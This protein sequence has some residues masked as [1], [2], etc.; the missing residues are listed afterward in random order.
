MTIGVLAVPSLA[1]KSRLALEFLALTNLEQVQVL[2]R[3]LKFPR[4]LGVVDFDRWKS[5]VMQADDFIAL[6][7]FRRDD[8]ISGIHRI[9][10]ANAQR[11]ECQLHGI[12]DQLHVLGQS[13]VAGKVKVA[14]AGLDDKAAGIPTITAIGQAAGMNGVDEA[15]ATEIKARA[16]VIDGMRLGRALFAK[17]LRDFKRRNN[18]RPG[19]LGNGYRIPD[20]VTVTVGNQ[21]VIGLETERIDILGQ[22]IA[23][24]KR[25]E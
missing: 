22:R 25:I 15:Q 10:A 8:R 20:V 13:G 4:R 17:P 23:G 19:L 6:D 2:P 3:F 24:D 5:V 14:F 11:R 12:A 21:N 18:R 16:A 9:V 7:I 1:G